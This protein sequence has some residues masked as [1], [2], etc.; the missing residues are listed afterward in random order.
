MIMILEKVPPNRWYGFRV[1]RT[2]ANSKIW[3]RGNRIFGYD[4]LGAGIALSVTAILTGLC[5]NNP[6]VINGINLGVLLISIPLALLYNL[7]AL[8]RMTD[9]T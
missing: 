3:Y 5:F 7:L 1:T 9:E 8:N 2:L 6:D 4:L